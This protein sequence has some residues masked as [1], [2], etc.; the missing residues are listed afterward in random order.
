MFLDKKILGDIHET[1]SHMWR[2]DVKVDDNDSSEAVSNF[3]NTF[4]EVFR[5]K[6]TAEKVT[7]IRGS[8]FYLVELPTFLSSPVQLG[9]VNTSTS[10]TSGITLAQAIAEYQ[11]NTEEGTEIQKK[12]Q[13]AIIIAALS[14]FILC[15]ILVVTRGAHYNTVYPVLSCS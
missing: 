7:L 5:D 14:F 11:M 4:E 2:E 3:S 15:L 10:T 6:Q 13:W 1:R 12:S 9:C 8:S